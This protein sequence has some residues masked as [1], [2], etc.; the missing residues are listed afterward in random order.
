MLDTKREQLRS[1]LI[2]ANMATAQLG[3]DE[4]ERKDQ[5]ASES[6]LEMIGNCLC[7]VKCLSK[8]ATIQ[9]C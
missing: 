2:D 1:Q 8:T 3:M 5:P 9:Q 6:Q 4:V 7:N